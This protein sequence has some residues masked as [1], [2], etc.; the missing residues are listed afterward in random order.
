MISR[1]S[2]ERKQSTLLTQWVEGKMALLL[3]ITSE[4]SFQGYTGS[5]DMFQFFVK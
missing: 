2:P 5:R 4:F 3:E 1:M